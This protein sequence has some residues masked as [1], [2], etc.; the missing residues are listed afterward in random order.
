MLVL[1]SAS[2]RR[3]ELLRREGILFVVH[4]ADLD[5]TPRPGESPRQCA[6]RLAREKA[7][8]VWQS[9]PADQ[10]LGADTVVAV[11]NEML[12]KPI[13]AADA[14]RMLRALSGRVHEVI[15]GVCL[16]TPRVT[17]QPQAHSTGARDVR[18]HSERTLVTMRSITE[19][20]IQEY[21]A[22]GE[23]MDK[24]GAYAIQGGAARWIPQIQGDYN[25]VVGLPLGLVSLMLSESAH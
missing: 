19:P 17:N 14:A 25:N 23:P 4:P 5:E 1:A 3:Q 20:E 2:P 18:T 6:E 8:A 10:V 24:A 21:I 13:D 15:T 12:G 22:T 7:L 9:R 11:D 16:V